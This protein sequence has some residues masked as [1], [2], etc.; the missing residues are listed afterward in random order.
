MI[1]SRMSTHLF[2]ANV[3]VPSVVGINWDGAPIGPFVDDPNNPN[4]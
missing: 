4:P 2:D 3:G 1:V